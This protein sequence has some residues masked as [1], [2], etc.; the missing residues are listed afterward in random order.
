M[1]V[2]QD[3]LRTLERILKEKAGLPVDRVIMETRSGTSFV[4]FHLYSGQETVKVR[5]PLL[6]IVQ[7]RTE[8]LALALAGMLQ[9]KALLIKPEGSAE[10]G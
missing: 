9:I 10:R 7:G 8:H 5:T 4:T 3:F 1:L 6:G 2:M